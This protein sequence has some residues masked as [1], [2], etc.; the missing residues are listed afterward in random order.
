MS[1]LQKENDSL[2]NKCSDREDDKAKLQ[3]PQRFAEE[4]LETERYQY[5]GKTSEKLIMQNLCTQ[6]C[7]VFHIVLLDSL[8]TGMLIQLCTL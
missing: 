7:V 5:R 6:V 3:A 1:Q 4:L 2:Q 8:L